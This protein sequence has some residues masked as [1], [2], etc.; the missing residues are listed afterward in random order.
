MRCRLLATWVT[1]LAISLSAAAQKRVS[2]L[3]LL[4]NQVQGTVRTTADKPV[5]DARVELRSLQSGLIVAS[6]YSNAQGFFTLPSAPNGRYELTVVSGLNESRE[7]VELSGSAVSVTMRVA[8]DTTGAEAGDDK[9]VS[10]AQYRVPKKARKE[11]KKAQE[12]TEKR[13][14][15]RALEQVEKALTLHPDFAEALTLKAI[16]ML[17]RSETDTAREAAEK[18]VAVDSSYGMGYLVLG[19]VYNAQGRY[20]DAI[21]TLDRGASLSPNAWQAYFELGKAYTAQ[22]K[23]EVALKNLRKAESLAADRHPLI[24]LVKA[25]ALLGLNS[26]EEAMTELQAYLEHAGGDPNRQHAAEM[27]DKVK[28]YV[29]QK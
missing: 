3:G 23:Y 10:V 11:F 1:I 25:H 28:A 22:K 15:P 27:M 2:D 9:S 21:R 19:A 6:G 4:N 16:L 20:D 7:T 12:A 24:N 8:E 29:A 18:A 14:I 5:A 26:F 17:D 13:D